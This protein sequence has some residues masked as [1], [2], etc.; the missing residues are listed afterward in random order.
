MQQK[1]IDLKKLKKGQAEQ[2]RT[3]SP[4]MAWPKRLRRIDN[5]TSQ[6]NREFTKPLRIIKTSAP[7]IKV[8]RNAPSF[9]KNVPLTPTQNLPKAPQKETVTPTARTE[10]Q[11][12]LNSSTISETPFAPLLSWQAPE[13]Q[14]E[15]PAQNTKIILGLG[16]LAFLSYSIYTQ[17]YLFAIVIAL[18][19]FV[20]YAYA[21]QPP[22]R[23]DFAVTTRG[24]KIQNRLYE[25][26]DLQS[27]WIFFDPPHVKELS[28]ES[29]KTFVPFLKIPLG[30]TKPTAVRE[31]LI[32][33]I[34][35]K[36]QEETLT[37]IVSRR[38]GL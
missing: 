16:T 33:F 38:F 2:Q 36:K 31:Q 32:K 29:K 5:K 19:S 14:N 35:E 21:H 37:E 28:I 15:T 7:T 8:L 9:F 6:I 1:I 25:F 26:Q 20:W 23:I 18:A 30:E 22:H 3:P 24:I 4:D 11:N 27:F 17:N 12:T 34:P 13:R 10:E